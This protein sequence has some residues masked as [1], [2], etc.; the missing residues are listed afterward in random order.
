PVN[1]REAKIYGA[2]FAG[3]HFF[4]DTGFGVQ[5]NYTIVKGDVSFDNLDITSNQFALLGLSDT[6]NFVLMY[7]NY[8]FEARLAYNWRDEFLNRTG[9]GANNPGYIEANTQIDANVTYHFTDNLSVSFEGIN[10]TG[11]D[12]REHARNED[13]LWGYDDLG[14][15]YQLGARYNF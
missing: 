7:E 9:A 12:R 2:E 10:L 3:Q 5:A 8:G 11:E 1:N 6:A 15:R 14:P 4:G 13:M